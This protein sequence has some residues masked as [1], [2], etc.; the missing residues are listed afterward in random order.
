MGKR[1]ALSALERRKARVRK[2]FDKQKALLRACKKRVRL[3]INVERRGSVSCVMTTTACM[4]DN[5]ILEVKPSGLNMPNDAK[6]SAGN[7]L[8]LRKDARAIQPDGLICSYELVN[9]I[10]GA[11][12]PILTSSEKKAMY[13]K[14]NATHVYS[15]SP[16][17]GYADAQNGIGG[18]ANSKS[19]GG[20]NNA[21]FLKGT[22]FVIASREIQPGQEILINYGRSYRKGW[23]D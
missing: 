15:Y 19:K 22:Y 3:N 18:M 21:K 1:K 5:P 12:V 2:E 4:E 9:G 14:D 23:L 10:D 8:F 20:K 11:S 17:M 13:S 6:Q 16:K 7:G